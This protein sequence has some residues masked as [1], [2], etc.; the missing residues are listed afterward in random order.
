MHCANVHLARQT[1]ELPP[2]HTLGLRDGAK[3]PTMSGVGD[4]V[5]SVILSF[6]ASLFTSDKPTTHSSPKQL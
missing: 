4:L 6:S 5:S 2:F 1:L 3:H